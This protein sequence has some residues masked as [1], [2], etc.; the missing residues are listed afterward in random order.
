MPL[1]M[2]LTN[3]R[4]IIGSKRVSSQVRLFR[5]FKETLMKISTERERH[6]VM[7]RHEKAQ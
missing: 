4:E 6:A 7:E 1:L 3:G 5:Y 2:R